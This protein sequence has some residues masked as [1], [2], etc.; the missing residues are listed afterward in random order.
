MS[1]KG[2]GAFRQRII[3]FGVVLLVASLI[4]YLARDFHIFKPVTIQSLLV[5]AIE[6]V[7]NESICDAEGWKPDRFFDQPNAIE[8]CQAISEHDRNRLSKLLRQ[9]SA[10]KVSGEGG[11]TVLYWAY[12]END[13]ESFK[14]LL[15]AGADTDAKLTDAV[16]LKYK[17]GLRPGDSILF[18][19]LMHNK[20]D[21][22]F[23][24]LDH[25]P[26][27]NQ[28]GCGNQSLL[29][30]ALRSGSII[31]LES[32]RKIIG[33][34]IDLN[35][36]DYRGSLAAYTALFNCKPNHCLMLLQEGIDRMD[37]STID[38]IVAEARGTPVSPCTM[39]SR[40]EL[41]AWIDE[42]IPDA[43]SESKSNE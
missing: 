38:D 7:A 12:F 10:L 17:R 20:F 18:T 19:C 13:L 42:H 37:D 6:E 41:L 15:A 33:T 2:R 43:S 31:S 8:I 40:A 9:P 36:R 34:G 29:H 21:F 3:I 39:E 23:A 1:K 11:V 26:N 32:F 27:V 22:F 30:T 4:I 14:K 24:A 5:Q 28:T 25:T 16:R 35:L